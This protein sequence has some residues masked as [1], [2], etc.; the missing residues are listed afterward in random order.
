MNATF[1]KFFKDL[2]VLNHLIV[3]I[4][5]LH[6]EAV[7]HIHDLAFDLIENRSMLIKI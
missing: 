5:L 1:L 3:S 2:L 4:I 7:A 6:L